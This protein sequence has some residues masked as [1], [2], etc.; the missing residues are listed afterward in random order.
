VPLFSTLSYHSLTLLIRSSSVSAITTKSSAHNSYGKA[1]RIGLD[2]IEQGLTSHQTHY[3]SYRGRVFTG[4]MTQPTVSKH[5]PTYHFSPDPIKSFFQIHKAKIELLSFS[6]KHLLYLSYNK[7]G[8]SGSF[9]FH[10]SKLHTFCINLL[11]NSVFEDPFHHFCSMFEQFNS[12]VR[13]TI[14]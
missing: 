6:S 13:S 10:K 12:S 3:R 7:N 8:I 1:T 2:W 11:P 4:Q 9:T 5:C 14:H